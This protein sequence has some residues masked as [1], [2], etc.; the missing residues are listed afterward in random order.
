MNWC[1]F[2]R[3]LGFGLSVALLLCCAAVV[4]PWGMPALWADLPREE[5][6]GLVWMLCFVTAGTVVIALR[7]SRHP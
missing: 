1:L 5:Q 7:E 3:S 2:F 6:H 4:P